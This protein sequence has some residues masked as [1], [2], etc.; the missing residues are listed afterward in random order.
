[1]DKLLEAEFIY[2]IEHTEWVSPIVV[3]PKKN[4]KLRV[5]VNLKQVNAVT[6]RDN[7]PLPITDHVL[8]RVEGKEAYSF[9][10][11]FSG[12]N[13][14]SIALE[15]QHKTA[16][17]IEWGI[18]AYRVMA[19]GL[20][21]ASATF[22]RLMPHA[23]KQYLRDFLEIFM[24]DLCVHS[25]QRFEHIDHLVKGKHIVSKHG[26]S[27]DMDKIKV[28]VDLPIPTN[29]R[30]VQ[31]FMG[32]CGYY[33]RFI[34]MYAEI[35]RPFY[36]LLVN[37]EWTPECTSS[38]DKLKKALTSAPI[39]RAP[40]YDK[41]IDVHID[42]SSYAIGYAN[43]FNIEWV[44]KWS[45]DVVSFLTTAAIPNEKL[46]EAVD[47][48]KATS[49]FCLIAG[50]LYYR[51]N[52]KK[53]MIILESQRYK[54]LGKQ[55]YKI[56]PDG[57]LRLCVPEE[58]YLEI[59]S[60]AHAGAGSGHFSAATI[61]KM[62][63]YS[64]L[65][66][67][68]LVMD[69]QAYVKRCDECQRNKI[70]TCYDNM[71]LRPIVSTRAFAKWGIDFVGPLPP[72]HGSRCQYLIVATDY[73]TKWAEALART[74]N[75]AYTTA[76]F[77]YENIFV[78]FGLPIE[79]VSDQ[80][81][82]FINEVIHVLL[83]EFLVTH[84]RSAPYHPQANGQAESTNKVLCTA[85]TKVVEG[86]RGTWEQKLPSVLWAYRKAYKTSIG[87]TPFELVYGLNAVLPIKFLLPTLQVAA[88]LQ[89]DGH[90]MSNRMNELEHLD[91]RRLTAIHAM[92]VENVDVKHGMIRTC[93]CKNSKKET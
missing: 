52:D 3:V 81:T 58:R 83:G 41:I 80:G 1:M 30:Q 84:R 48:I 40:V 36:G 8:E 19:F 25:K 4:G 89:W 9:L 43:L 35:A 12:Y 27:T 53:R 63:L 50:H 90:A 2:E 23:F 75:D 38:F 74:K 5:Y 70:P 76:K 68:T 24:D 21:N 45:I 44:P 17:A 88:E 16:F 92:Y 18:Y 31:V 39:L 87:S 59:L 37:F 78:R 79:I 65:W 34:Y 67:P 93:V 14:V 57:H 66:W 73:L 42:A 49:N 82:H 61:S 29:P 64:G 91:E 28:I 26:I 60:H 55:L 46:E 32:H 7:Y 13:Q 47:F 62:V 11:G 15:D 54:V 71:P 22:Q 85:L 20:T 51:D 56:G 33:R 10:D 77:L 6:I 86:N 72:A 69:S